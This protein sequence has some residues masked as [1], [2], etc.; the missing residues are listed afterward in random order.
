VEAL[1]QLL[2]AQHLAASVGEE[3]ILLPPPSAEAATGEFLL[4]TLSYGRMKLTPLHRRRENFIKHIGIFSITAG[5][6]TKVAQLLLLGLLN[7]GIPFLLMDWS[8]S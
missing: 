5:G 7:K 6:K 3:A 1:I 4:G 8:R 2:A